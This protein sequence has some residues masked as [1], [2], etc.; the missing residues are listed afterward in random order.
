MRETLANGLFMAYLIFDIEAKVS[1]KYMPLPKASHFDAV[2]TSRAV[3][4]YEIPTYA[5]ENSLSG[6]SLSVQVG[7]VI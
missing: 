3:E 2:R 7:I 5:V 4:L 1:N 6:G